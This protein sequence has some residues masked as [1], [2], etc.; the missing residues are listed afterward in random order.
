MLGLDVRRNF[1]VRMLFLCIQRCTTGSSPYCVMCTLLVVCYHTALETHPHQIAYPECDVKG[2]LL[3]NVH[4]VVSK[5]VLRSCLLVANSLC[6]I[7][8]NVLFFLCGYACVFQSNSVLFQLF[9]ESPPDV[10]REQ[11]VYF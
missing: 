2:S 9:R 7:V 1:G 8:S 6:Y 10:R 3:P 4:A 11:R 5:I